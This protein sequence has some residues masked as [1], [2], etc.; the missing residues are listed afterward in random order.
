MHGNS[1]CSRFE[2]VR[3]FEQPDAILLNTWIVVRIDGRGFHKLSAKYGFEK[4]SDRRAL[5]LSNA[6][7]AGVMREVQELVVAYGQSDE[8]R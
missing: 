7:A 6:A 4:P 3:A 2:Y 5:D 8:Y 1:L